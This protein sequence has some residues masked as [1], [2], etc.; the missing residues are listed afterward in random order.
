[1]VLGCKELKGTEVVN[2]I[3]F[4]APPLF[5]VLP[6]WQDVQLDSPGAP[7]HEFGGL[8]VKVRADIDQITNPL[9]ITDLINF[10]FM[11]RKSDV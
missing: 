9:A 4:N 1:V 8:F 7:V 11:F 2:K 10:V 5:N 6:P 3:L